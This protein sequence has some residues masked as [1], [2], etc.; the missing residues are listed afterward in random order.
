M[1]CGTVSHSEGQEAVQLYPVYS[2]D[3]NS[4]N[5]KW[6]KAT[7]GGSLQL[8]ISNPDAFGAFEP[9]KEYFVDIAPAT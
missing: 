7:P 1:K 5:A 3:P 4:E 2:A 9:G 6:A 8:T